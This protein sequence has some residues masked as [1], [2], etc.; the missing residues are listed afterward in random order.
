MDS[1]VASFQKPKSRRREKKRRIIGSKSLQLQIKN[2]L[3]MQYLPSTNFADMAHVYSP[4]WLWK[5]FT[6]L[7][8][9]RFQGA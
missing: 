8:N 9:A 1:E 5:I 2:Q 7:K 6:C 3:D 4:R